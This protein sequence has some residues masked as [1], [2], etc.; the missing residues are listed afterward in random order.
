MCGRLRYRATQRTHAAATSLRVK[1]AAF[2]AAVKKG[3]CGART[4]AAPLPDVRRS[5]YAGLTSSSVCMTVEKQLHA[6]MGRA[7]IQAHDEDITYTSI[8]LA[9]GKARTAAACVRVC[10]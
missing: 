10:T 5:M 9:T 7:A 8:H 1:A 2:T 3:L 6:R 4:C